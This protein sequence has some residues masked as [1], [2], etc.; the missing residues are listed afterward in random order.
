MAYSAIGL[1]ARALLKVGASPI[2]SFQD[3]TAEAELAAALY[4]PTRDALLAAHGWSFAMKQAALARLADPPGVDFAHGFA[5][6]D[7]FLRALSLG[8]GG[9]GRGL[10][11]RIQQGQLL[12]DAPAVTLTYVE[13][14]AEGRFPAFFDAA[15]IARLAAEFCIPLTENT[16]RAETLLKSAE[17]EFRRARL[18]DMSQDNQPGFEDFTLIEARLS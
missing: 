6:P 8:T 3:G 14:A 7:D 15:L 9:R 17:I 4:A 11:Y 5:L 18:I 16:S 10:S 12:A 13:R 1:C 2:T